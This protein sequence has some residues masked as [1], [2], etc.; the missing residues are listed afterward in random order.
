MKI[1]YVI[2]PQNLAPCKKLQVIKKACEG[3]AHKNPE[4]P[5][6]FEF[7][8]NEYIYIFSTHMDQISNETYFLIWNSFNYRSYISSNPDN[9]K[10]DSSNYFV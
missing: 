6:K 1:N 9:K 4:N 2:T 8:I 3:L 5:V 7:E 10:M